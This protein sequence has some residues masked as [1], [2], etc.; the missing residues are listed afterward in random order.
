MEIEGKAVVCRDGV[1]EDGDERLGSGVGRTSLSILSVVVE[2]RR[3]SMIQIVVQ[4]ERIVIW[5]RSE[6]VVVWEWCHVC[7][8]SLV[9]LGMKIV[10]RW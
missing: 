9:D 8:H 4:G 3:R 1:A 5:R 6:L 10:S 7:E 2:E